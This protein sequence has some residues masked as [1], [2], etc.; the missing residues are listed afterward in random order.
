MSFGNLSTPTGLGVFAIAPNYKNPYTDRLTL[1]WEQQLA[2]D[3]ALNVDFTYAKSYQL[4]RLQD[5][6]IQYATNPDGSIK[7]AA[8]GQPMYSSTRPDPFYGRITEYMSDAQ[9][10]YTAVVVTLRRQF[11]ERLFGF[12]SVTWSQDFDNDSNERNYSGIQAQD[13]HNLS[14]EWA[15]SIRDQRWKIALNGVWNTPWWGLSLSGVYHYY[16]GSPFTPYTSSDLNNDGNF[17]DRPTVNGVNLGRNSYRYPDFASLDLRLQ[18]A[19]ALGPGS[20]S[21]IAECFNCGNNANWSVNTAW[22]SNTST[23]GSSFD[24]RLLNS[25]TIAFP[26]TYQFAIRYDF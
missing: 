14:N 2:K 13:S 23:P 4:E 10:K 3:T 17:T 9:S 15:Y 26:R 8:N 22:G 12:A 21:L 25:S 7:T 6:N 5:A 18:K 16:T 24:S 19:F 20:L 11:T 1:G